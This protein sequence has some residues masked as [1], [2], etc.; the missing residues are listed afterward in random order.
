MRSATLR[1]RRI[2]GFTL[3]VCGVLLAGINPS[4]S[5][6]CYRLSVTMSIITVRVLTK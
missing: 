2:M 3:A 1:G 4:V 6:I 5:Y